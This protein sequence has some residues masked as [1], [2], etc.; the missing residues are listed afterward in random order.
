MQ[1]ARILVVDDDESVLAAL[2]DELAPSFDVTCAG[3]G[4]QALGLLQRERFDLLLSD[5]RMPGMDGVSLLRRAKEVDPSMMQVL[6]TAYADEDASAAAREPGGAYKLQKPWRDELEIV[7]RRAL[8]HRERLRRMS[9]MVSHM[10]RLARLGRVM[11]ET[12]HEMSSPLSY[13]RANIQTLGRSLGAGVPDAAD[14]AATLDDVR[15]GVDRLFD[16]VKR[17][18]GYAAPARAT[19]M[20][21]DLR[22]AAEQAVRITEPQFRARVDVKTVAPPEAVTLVGHAHEIEQVIVNL[23]VNAAE[24]MD[25]QGTMRVE[26]SADETTGRVA[27][28]DEGPGIPPEL[29]DRI[30]EPFFSTKPRAERQGGGL[31]LGLA[32]S[33]DIA[34]RYGGRLTVRSEVGRGATFTLELPRVLARA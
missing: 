31:G 23:L 25:W 27:V 17:L 10:D 8:E 2:A 33:L 32:V 29:M 6:L 15:E 14:A 18:R 11:A 26:V 7:L 4:E 13:V 1:R 19:P 20:P 34:R 28:A 24:A 9:E 3:G 12:A 16:L 5:V 22:A 30:F 21:F